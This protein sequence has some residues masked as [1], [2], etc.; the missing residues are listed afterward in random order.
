MDI[1][2]AREDIEVV[3]RTTL[4]LGLQGMDLLCC[5]N[6]GCTETK[7]TADCQ[8]S[9]PELKRIVQKCENKFTEFL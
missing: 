2:G 7:L 3:L 5:G 6:L 1:A 4:A 9:R 8:L